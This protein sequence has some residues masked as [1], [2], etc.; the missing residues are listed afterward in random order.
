MT[1]D[2]ETIGTDTD[3]LGYGEIYILHTIGSRDFTKIKTGEVV[4]IDP[5]DLEFEVVSG[6][7]RPMGVETAYRATTYI[8]DDE[9]VVDVY[10]YPVGSVEHVEFQYDKSVYVEGSSNV[11]RNMRNNILT[12]PIYTTDL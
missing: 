4:T 9:F 7:E 12:D 1:D 10:E 2:F 3:D 8:G 5:S 6:D 11:Y